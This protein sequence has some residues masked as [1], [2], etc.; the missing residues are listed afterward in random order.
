M[1]TT[2]CH[3]Q[4]QSQGYDTL[5]KHIGLTSAFHRVLGKVALQEERPQEGRVSL[6]SGLTVGLFLP[7]RAA[8]V[9]SPK[10]FICVFFNSHNK[11]KGENAIIPILEMKKSKLQK[12]LKPS[13]GHPAIY[14]TA[15][16]GPQAYVLPKLGSFHSALEAVG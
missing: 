12:V 1:S 14:G 16:A 4:G 13:Q 3:V 9:L 5:Q 10:R 8:L 2:H 6:L 7:L 15:R 11:L